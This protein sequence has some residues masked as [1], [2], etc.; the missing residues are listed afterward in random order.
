MS[1]VHTGDAKTK[2]MVVQAGSLMLFGMIILF[3]VIS[4]QKAA[5]GVAFGHE[6]SY[7]AL[8]GFLI[9][10][11]AWLSN[12]NMIQENIIFDDNVLFYFCIP[13]IVFAS[14]Y[15]MRRKRFFQNFTNIMI[16]G[17]LGTL[18][19]YILFAGF[20]LWIHSYNWMTMYNATTGEWQDLVLST[21]EILL[22]SSLLC[23]TDVIAAISMVKYEE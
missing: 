15:N 12:N 20:T 16:F 4:Q 10:L 17:V 7:I 11:C 8:I 9:S 14:G 23:S 3:I 2:P 1:D 5:R 22:M 13:P 18:V 21:P 6:A 19:T